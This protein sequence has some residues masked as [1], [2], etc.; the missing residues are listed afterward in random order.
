VTAS[1]ASRTLILPNG[2]AVDVISRKEALFL[3]Q[4]IFV[5]R[6]YTAAMAEELGEGVVVI[7]AG[8][9]IG[10]FTL[11]AHRQWPATRFVAVEPIPQIHDVLR[12]NVERHGVAA[13]L[14]SS[15]L[16]AFAGEEEFRFYPG[17]SVLSGAESCANGTAPLLRQIVEG[18]GWTQFAARTGTD[19]A[20]L[21]DRLNAHLDYV[22]MVRPVMTLS[23]L[24][25]RQAIECVD[26]LKV[27][28][29][30]SELQVLKGVTDEDWPRIRRIALEADGR[31][32]PDI[33][34]LLRAKSY[35]VSV[36]QADFF[37]DTS[38]TMIHA[39]RWPE[40][41]RRNPR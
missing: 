17:A 6:V 10:M 19:P 2:L 30:G 29:E 38:V 34:S 15:G 9:N 8:A 28:V 1:E 3:Y 4:E 33:V 37:M 27:D 32:A 16:S 13:T 14:V 23:D 7:D 21:T 26:L 5:D 36:R 41:L 22:R 25:H 12:R 24:M 40:T 35:E 20:R 39:W 18:P 11:F 31:C